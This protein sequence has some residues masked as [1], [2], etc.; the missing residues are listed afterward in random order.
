MIYDIFNVLTRHLASK[1]RNS[2]GSLKCGKCLRYY[3]HT[4]LCSNSYAI[5]KVGFV[6]HFSFSRFECM[7]LYST[8]NKTYFME[9]FLT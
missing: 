3:M 7:V 4:E 1:I 8:V 6:E 5:D 2:A 9:K